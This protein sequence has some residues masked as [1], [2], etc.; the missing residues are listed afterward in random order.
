MAKCFQLFLT[1]MD[2]DDGGQDY[3]GFVAKF[4]S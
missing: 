1:G 3:F 4:S 2:F